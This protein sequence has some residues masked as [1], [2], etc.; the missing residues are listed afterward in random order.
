[1]E[2]LGGHSVPTRGQWSLL[3][4]FDRGSVRR[5]MKDLV[6][7]G[8]RGFKG[9]GK[10]TGPPDQD[11]DLRSANPSTDD[12][13][14]YVDEPPSEEMT[15]QVEFVTPESSALRQI[16]HVRTETESEY[17]R[18]RPGERR[19]SDCGSIGDEILVECSLT[20]VEQ[21][22]DVESPLSRRTLSSTDSTDESPRAEN[23]T[24]LDNH[25]K[26]YHGTHSEQQ[27]DEVADNFVRQVSSRVGHDDSGDSVQ[28]E[29]VVQVEE[30]VAEE[31]GLN[32]GNGLIRKHSNLVGLNR[33]I[34]FDCC[35]ELAQTNAE[36]QSAGHKAS[37]RSQMLINGNS[38]DSSIP[39]IEKVVGDK[40]FQILEPQKW[41]ERVFFVV[42]EN[43]IELPLKY[44]THAEMRQVRFAGALD[45]TDI[46]TFA[47]PIMSP[48]I[49]KE[50]RSEQNPLRLEHVP[51]DTIKL[52]KLVGKWEAVAGQALVDSLDVKTFSKNPRDKKPRQKPGTTGGAK[53]VPPLHPYHAPLSSL[54]TW[55][56]SVASLNKSLALDKLFV[57]TDEGAMVFFSCKHFSQRRT[58]TVLGKLLEAR[59]CIV[60]VNDD[61][62]NIKVEAV[63]AGERLHCGFRL[64]DDP[65]SEAIKVSFLIPRV[66]RRNYRT[67]PSLAV[68]Y[69]SFFS[70]LSSDFEKFVSLYS[71]AGPSEE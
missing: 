39:Q 7:L 9:N 31:A 66:E 42:G 36:E 22:N 49:W 48:A 21:S 33:S 40:I 59:G 51:K 13:G 18:D 26:D 64:E 46:G 53:D 19:E 30:E 61:L 14:W 60:L 50:S 69:T 8:K 38:L 45:S 67:N 11:F 24:A 16:A 37:S 68:A 65:A 54:K 10:S 6:G 58:T 55:M 3:R 17:R 43:Y 32:E 47:S 20:S 63:H 29:T 57:S 23:Y 1:M 41:T 35:P 56:P 28:S 52:L 70:D 62:E 15:Y 27:F 2:G 71:F 5:T 12:L 4:K 44:P 25:L 34:S